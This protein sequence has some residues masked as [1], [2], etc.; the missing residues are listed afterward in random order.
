M[1]KEEYIGIIE[2]GYCC[3]T[4][5]KRENELVAGSVCNAGFLDH[6]TQTYNDDF[7]LDENLQNFIEWIEFKETEEI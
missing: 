4:I 5:V 3:F 6:Y 1:N 2:V 7:S